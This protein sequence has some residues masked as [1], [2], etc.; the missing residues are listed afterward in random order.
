MSAGKFLMRDDILL[1]KHKE[2]CT[3]TTGR[4]G[5]LVK[6]SLAF[7]AQCCTIR[8]DHEYFPDNSPL[9]STA[10]KVEQECYAL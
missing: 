1:A 9:V 3:T 4:A 8:Q 7:I 2:S 10:D 6:A 5:S